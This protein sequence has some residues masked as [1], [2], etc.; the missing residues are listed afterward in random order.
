[1]NSDELRRLQLTEL[2]LLIDF[3]NYC[4]KHGLKYYLIGGAL[5]GAERYNHFIP[6]DDDIDVA[7]P[8]EDYELF[9]QIWKKD[10]MTKYFLQSSK[11]DPLF[12]RGILK[13]RIK[14]THIIEESCKN[15]KFLNDG[16]YIDIFPID[17][18]DENKGKKMEMKG[19]KIRFLA[20]MKTI[21]S[22]YDNKRFR[23]IKKIISIFLKLV[24][25]SYLDNKLEKIC[26][27]ENSKKRKYA[28]L[29]LHNY[30]WKKQ[31]HLASIFEEGSTCIFEGHIFCAPKNKEAFLLK[32]FGSDYLVESPKELQKQPHKYIEIKF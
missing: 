16:I 26:T 4:K 19:K 11:T 23:Y 6:W 15:I 20:T 24:P 13:L 12:A 21:K 14:G 1:M 31:I 29:F 9:Q 18:V 7:M 8:R 5:L 25:T 30:G 32:V 3:D 10:A 28:V 22:G 27:E 2:E 17:F